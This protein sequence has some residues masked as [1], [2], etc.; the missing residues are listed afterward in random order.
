M[1]DKKL[2][3]VLF[4]P[5]NRSVGLNTHL[6]VQLISCRRGKRILLSL[7][8]LN[9]LNLVACSGPSE[10]ERQSGVTSWGIRD[11][12]RPIPMEPGQRTYHL[13]PFES[14][15]AHDLIAFVREEKLIAIDLERQNGI[16]IVP[17]RPHHEV[18]D[19]SISPSGQTL[20]ASFNAFTR[21][22]EDYISVI[23]DDWASI[24][25]FHANGYSLEGAQ[26]LNDEMVMTDI[27]TFKDNP[28]KVSIISPAEAYSYV[29]TSKRALSGSIGL[30]NLNTLENG[31]LGT[32]DDTVDQFALGRGY[33]SAI[34][35]SGN[36]F[37]LRELWLV[38]QPARIPPDLPEIGGPQPRTFEFT[39]D[40][41]ARVPCISY[42][43]EH[44]QPGVIGR[45]DHGPVF[46][47]SDPN[48]RGFVSE[49]SL[50]EFSNLYPLVEI[51]AVDFT[52]TR[53]WYQ[54]NDNRFMVL[55]ERDDTF[56]LSGCDV[57]ETPSICEEISSVR[58]NAIIPF[59][60]HQA[61]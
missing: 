5:T 39:V 7:A 52:T 48:K 3:S 37:F 45:L 38:P 1:D 54:F 53:F 61:E 51:G 32:C 47:A 2:K 13:Q 11:I 58:E 26:L 43:A 15:G 31:D 25:L 17:L 27:V 59:Q 33:P 23:S 57:S 41:T 9:C 44:E 36:H 40:A 56:V 8:L 50:I 12:A 22:G 49:G 14:S 24:R 19:Y 30:L 18:V 10:N 60:I 16:E 35:S 46:F 6:E 28:D 34:V 29:W 4:S 55:A 20:A 21:G 42:T